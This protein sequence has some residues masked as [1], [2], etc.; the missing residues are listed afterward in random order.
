MTTTID[1]TTFKSVSRYANE[2]KN[3]LFFSLNYNTILSKLFNSNPI[4]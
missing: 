4:E 1:L 3:I 2:L